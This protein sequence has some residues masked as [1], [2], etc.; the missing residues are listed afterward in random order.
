[1]LFCIWAFGTE[2]STSI[3]FW[4]GVPHD[5][6]VQLWISERLYVREHL[7]SWLLAIAA[8]LPASLYWQW[9]RTRRRSK[10]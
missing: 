7:E 1:V 9:R 10:G 3:R 5:E 2:Y 4:Q 8:I 6:A